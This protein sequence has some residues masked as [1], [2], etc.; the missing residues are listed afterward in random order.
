VK[1]SEIFLRKYRRYFV[2]QKKRKGKRN[3]F[4]LLIN[5]SGGGMYL[6]HLTH[7]P[8]AQRVEREVEREREREE[9]K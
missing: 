2:N 7:S 8:P 9:G 4:V 1:I 3:S 5:M 6:P